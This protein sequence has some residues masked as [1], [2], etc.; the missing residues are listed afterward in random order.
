MEKAPYFSKMI[1]RSSYLPPSPKWELLLLPSA[2]GWAEKPKQKFVMVPLDLA[3][4]HPF[5]KESSPRLLQAVPVSCK[6]WSTTGSMKEQELL[7]FMSDQEHIS[8]KYSDLISLLLIL[9]YICTHTWGQT[10]AAENTKS[11][12]P[13][14][15]QIV[16]SGFVSK[17]EETKEQAESLTQFLVGL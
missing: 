17:P 16:S 12:T 13:G 7:G 9:S 6:S 1:F 11:C 8:Q 10:S 3:Q 4:I 2:V 15:A 14:R 5:L